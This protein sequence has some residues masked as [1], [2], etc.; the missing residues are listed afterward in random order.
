MNPLDAVGLQPN[1]ALC[2]MLSLPRA[3]RTE[4]I[5]RVVAL[6]EA[7][8]PVSGEVIVGSGPESRRSSEVR[9]SLG[10][11]RDATAASEAT[12]Y[13]GDAAAASERRRSP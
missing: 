6:A 10:G 13:L 8:E 5:D 7:I 4:E 3:L 2:R 11:L 1:E 9:R 12:P